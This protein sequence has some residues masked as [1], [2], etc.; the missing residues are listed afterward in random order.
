MAKTHDLSGNIVEGSGRGGVRGKERGD[1]MSKPTVS[2]QSGP[3]TFGDLS[4]RK[5]LHEKRHRKLGGQPR[6]AAKG[7]EWKNA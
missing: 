2:F 5:S 4:P 6:A 7:M 3:N 1:V